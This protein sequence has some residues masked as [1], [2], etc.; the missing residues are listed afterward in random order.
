[1]THTGSG[2]AQWP[3]M[4]TSTRSATVA[5]GTQVLANRLASDI[6]AH[7]HEQALPKG[8]HLTEQELADRFRVSRTPIRKALEVLCAM[9]V[10]TKERDRGYFLEKPAAGGALTPARD[11]ESE[12]ALYF[13]I[14]EDRL[15]GA[16]PASFT[17]ADLMRRYGVSRVQIASLLQRM[18]HEGWV[19]RLP[20]RG[21]SF[22][23]ILES[24]RAYE[25]CFRFRAL[26]ELA[27]ITEPDYHLDPDV[28]ARC[29]AEQRA[30]L[31]GGLLRYSRAETFEIGA[32]FHEIIV[33]GAQDPFLLDAIQRIN[34]L[35]RL[36][37]YRTQRDRK[38]LIQ[39]CK[40][41]LELLAMIE[42]RDMK[43][44]SAFL[45][46]HLDLARK[47]KTPLTF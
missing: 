1:V 4:P 42:K 9:G 8:A 6:L 30:M 24:P 2:L 47:L 26:I 15:A 38:R 10:V 20:A 21:W 32:R 18:A 34:R 35:R 44:A 5:K 23:P 11:D 16:L 31:D 29:R 25:R 14:A 33:S 36:L 39:S 46:K 37:D 13:R 41:H 43:A 27:A 45:R 17:E 40:E 12:D 19:E 28:I 3:A 7:L 22:T